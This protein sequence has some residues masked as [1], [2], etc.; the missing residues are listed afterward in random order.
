MVIVQKVN[1]P[2]KHQAESFGHV[3]FGLTV[4]PT[5]YHFGMLTKLKILSK[6]SLLDLIFSDDTLLKTDAYFSQISREH[7][8][9][10]FLLVSSLLEVVH[11]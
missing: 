5:S 4:T 6:V 11:W 8:T 9:I 7:T 10:L 2:T 1:L 3:M